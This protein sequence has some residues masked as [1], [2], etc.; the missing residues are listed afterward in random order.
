MNFDGNEPIH[1]AV[2]NRHFDIVQILIELTGDHPNRDG[3]T[4]LHLAALEGNITTISN[5]VAAGANIHP[6]NKTGY[7]PLQYAII[8]RKIDAVLIFI[9]LDTD[10]KTVIALATS[11]NRNDIADDINVR[12]TPTILN[13]PHAQGNIYVNETGASV[14]SANS[15]T[16]NNATTKASVVNSTVIAPPIE[17]PSL[18]ITF[19]GANAI[20]PSL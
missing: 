9:L 10:P 13:I 7:T 5:L 15:L 19:R 20:A 16:S 8:N 11:L 2:F 17:A 6:G 14:A 12:I 3:Y 1:V 18:P 4:P